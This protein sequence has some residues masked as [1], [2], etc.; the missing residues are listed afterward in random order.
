MATGKVLS[1]HRGLLAVRLKLGVSSTS[2]VAGNV[3]RLDDGQ[4]AAVLCWRSGLCFAALPAPA[5]SAVVGS[6]VVY[7]RGESIMLGTGAALG[8]RVIDCH[9]I[10][11]DR[12]PPPV[13]DDAVEWPLLGP[14]PAATEKACRAWIG[15]M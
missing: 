14:V 7:E 11:L 13:A 8:G 9:G 2:L 1:L 15:I 3:L 6:E 10:P 12:L 4:R 5:A